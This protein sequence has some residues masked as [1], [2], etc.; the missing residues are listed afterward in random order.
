[1]A[2]TTQE[3]KPRDKGRAPTLREEETLRDSQRDRSK[4]SSEQRTRSREELIHLGKESVPV[5][6]EDT[7]GHFSS[8]EYFLLVFIVNKRP[9]NTSQ[10]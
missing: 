9:T 8:I 3:G 5:A 7:L 10:R 2:E 1:M 4:S 6:F